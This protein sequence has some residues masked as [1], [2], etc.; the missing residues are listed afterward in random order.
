M[1]ALVFK[2]HYNG[3]GI[4]QALG[5]RG[6]EVHAVDSERSVGTMSRYAT[7][8]RSPDPL[9]EE[10]AFVEFLLELGPRFRD[11]PVLF[12][13]HDHWA[14]AIA[15]HRDRLSVHYE[16]CVAAGPVLE[17]LINKQSFYEWGRERGYPVPRSWRAADVEHIPA[18]AYPL[19]AKPEHRVVASDDPANEARSRAL[20]GLRLTV[21]E[22]PAAARAFVSR[23]A[24][25]VDDL[26]LQQYVVGLSDCMYTIGVYVDRS[27]EVRG[28][29]TGRKVRGYPADIGDCV[30]GQA[31]A[32]PRELVELATEICR[33]IEYVGIAEFE[34]KRDADTGAFVLIEI[35]PRSWSWQ[36][37]TPACGVDLVAMAYADLTGSAPVERVESRVPDGSVKWVRVLDDFKNCLFDYRR[38]GYPE[39]RLGLRAWRNSLR[40]DHLVIAEFAKDDPVPGL[41]AIFDRARGLFNRLV[42]S[43]GSS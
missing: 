30:V 36:S 31:E 8:V 25:W 21:L 6:I 13:S 27:H 33:E 39:W 40:A 16:P 15:R 7:F 3:L 35:N 12:P 2:C 41:R 18:D 43:R 19:A 42:F 28:V 20:D 10:S 22:S 14:L 37:I 32:M 11:R 29:F 5:R 1:S 26:L 9:T 24:E 38:D 4:I 17:L 34:F 23:H